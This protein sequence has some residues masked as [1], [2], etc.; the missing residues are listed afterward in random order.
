MLE[1]GE[2]TGGGQRRQKLELIGRGVLFR[3][4]RKRRDKERGIVRQSDSARRSNRRDCSSSLRYKINL[5]RRRR[6][7]ALFG[8]GEELVRP[9]WVKS[10]GRMALLKSLLSPGDQ[11]Y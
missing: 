11:R 10:I 8:A 7:V 2:G 1:E 4:R 3:G 5:S 9:F 6:R